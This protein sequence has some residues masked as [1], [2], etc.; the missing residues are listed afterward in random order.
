MSVRFPEG[1]DELERRALRKFVLSLRRDC[2]DD[3]LFRAYTDHSAKIAQ[4]GG[5]ER[6]FP[7]IIWIS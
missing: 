1:M 7:D 5:P 4:S 3:I 6:A 2:P